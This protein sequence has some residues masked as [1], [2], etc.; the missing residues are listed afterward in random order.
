MTIRRAEVSDVHTRSE[1]GQICTDLRTS[2]SQKC[3]VVLRRSRISGSQKFVSLN[4]RLE[5]DKEEKKVYR[6]V[7]FESE[8]LLAHGRSE[9]KQLGPP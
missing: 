9:R 1:L 6:E 4:S 8:A 3:E 7:S 2:T 5:S